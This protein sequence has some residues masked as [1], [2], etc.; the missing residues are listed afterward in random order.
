[1]AYRYIR[2]WRLSLSPARIRQVKRHALVV[3]GLERV[4]RGPPSRITRYWLIPPDKRPK[5]FMPHPSMSSDEMRAR[6]QGVWDNFYAL[7]AIW[8][9][10]ACTPTLRARL[11]FVLISKLY[12]QMYASTGIA[13]D[14][15]RRERA[16][17]WAR[18]IAKI[19]RRLFQARPMPDLQLPRRGTGASTSA[20]RVLG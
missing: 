12:R 10:S 5:M 20:L 14:S 16:T 11:A 3:V 9:R 8:K 15:A 1:M 18:R 7:P 17:L 19:T 6:T 13:T 2:W 4:H